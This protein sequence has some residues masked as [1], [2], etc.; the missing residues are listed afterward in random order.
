MFFGIF[1]FIM[2][3]QY[4]PTGSEVGEREGDGIGKGLRAATRNSGHRSATALYVIT[5]PTRLLPPTTFFY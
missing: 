1:A 5:L 3:G 4:L 2:I